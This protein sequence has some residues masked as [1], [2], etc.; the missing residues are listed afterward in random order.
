MFIICQYDYYSN[1]YATFL[2]NEQT[3]NFMNYT[4]LYCLVNS[5]FNVH[6]IILFIVQSYLYNLFVYIIW[7]NIFAICFIG[8]IFLSERR[9]YV[10]K[11][12]I[13]DWM[14][15]YRPVSSSGNLD[16]GVIDWD[17]N[18]SHTH[19]THYHNSIVQ[20]HKQNI[21]IYTMFQY[22]FHTLFL[23]LWPIATTAV[24][25]TLDYLRKLSVRR[26]TI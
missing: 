1:T 16:L 19:T 18:L 5:L 3:N 7:W 10:T 15:A 23:K 14:Y 2:M 21:S 13:C 11:K 8:R 24:R 9:T 20:S 22:L 6:I 4:S 26:S 12:S 25:K 17:T